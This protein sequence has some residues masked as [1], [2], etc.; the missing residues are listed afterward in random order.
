MKHY[1]SFKS[2]P[3]LPNGDPVGQ[4]PKWS[5]GSFLELQVHSGTRTRRKQ[6][7]QGCFCVLASS[8]QVASPPSN[9]APLP[10]SG[11]SVLHLKQ[12]AYSS[13]LRPPYTFGC[14]LFSEPHICEFWEFESQEISLREVPGNLWYCPWVGAKCCY[15][16]H[17]FSRAFLHGTESVSTW[18]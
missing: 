9:A 12:E 14:F 6:V 2:F 18:Q 11:M 10:C 15:E 7:R 5:H 1:N 16:K 4:W 3:Y 8:S 17:L 13:C